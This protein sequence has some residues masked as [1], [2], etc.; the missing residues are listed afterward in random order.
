MKKIKFLGAVVLAA[1]LIFAG[2]ANGS[3]DEAEPTSAAP[4]ETPANGEN[5]GSG[6]NTGSETNSGT[7]TGSEENSGAGQNAGS[8]ENTGSTGN[9]GNTGSDNSSS[10]SNSGSSESGEN[11][12]SNTEN[13]SGSVDEDDEEYTLEFSDAANSSICENGVYIVSV[14]NANDSEWGNQIF[15]KNPNAAAGIAAGDKI[16]TTITLEADKDIGVMFVKNQFNGG[17]YSG[18]DTQK[19]LPANTATV[20]D[21]YGTVA[22][23][24]DDSSS[25]VLAL[26]GNAAD[27]ELKI[28]AINVE[29]LGNYAVESIAVSPASKTIK[30]GETITFK[31]LD[32]YGFEIPEATVEI[33]SDSSS[34]IAG[35]VLTAASVDEVVSV[36]AS[37]ES[38]EATATITV[39]K[40]AAATESWGLDLTNDVTTI[41]VLPLVNVVAWGGAD[42]APVVE[43]FAG[44]KAIKFTIPANYNWIGAAWQGDPAVNKID[45]SGYSTIIIKFNDSEFAEGQSLTDYNVKLKG[46]EEKPMKGS[47][48]EA[49][50]D[51]WKTITISLSDYSNAGVTLSEITC[52][53]FCDWKAGDV[54]PGE[55]ALYISEVSFNP[56]E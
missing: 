11:P 55:G 32:Q 9:T 18:I 14:A 25:I 46:G 6:E 34:T 37:Y 3:D 44:R 1:S 27:T 38:F 8:G 15:I 5:S 12:G 50:A 24:Y 7:N 39:E 23:D 10:G 40:I 48:S 31:V 28:S 22:A 4:V 35:K 30:E 54:N 36:K 21:I 20:F 42:T 2:C 45:V 53:N 26:R 51:G 41:G 17:S 56:A 49:D 47:V 13:G 52:I 33:V 29:K 16:H 19:A 43:E